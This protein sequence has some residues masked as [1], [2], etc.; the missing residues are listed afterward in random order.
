MLSLFAASASGV[1]S[2]SG[3]GHFYTFDGVKF[4]YQGT[5]RA[6]FASQCVQ[7]NF[8][9]VYVTGEKRGG[10]TSVAYVG[11]VIAR[12]GPSQGGSR[13]IIGH[14][15]TASDPVKV[16]VSKCAVLNIW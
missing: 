7:N 14:Y 5:C 8:V 4:D 2:W 1:C 3:G 11:Y 12:F 6:T 16:L 13:V 15:Q 9:T 10:V